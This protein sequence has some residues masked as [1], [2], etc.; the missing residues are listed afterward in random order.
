MDVK[1]E[2]KAYSTTERVV[3]GHEAADKVEQNVAI[4]STQGTV[5]NYQAKTKQ[6]VLVVKPG[7]SGPMKLA[8]KRSRKLPAKGMAKY[9]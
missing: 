6:N 5:N 2:K 3:I 1:A 9:G 4:S 7:S 8:K